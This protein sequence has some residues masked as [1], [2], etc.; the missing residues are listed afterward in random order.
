[1]LR[2]DFIGGM[3]LAASGVS[4]V[5]TRT[6]EGWAGVTVSAV[7]SVSADPPALLVCINQL[8]RLARAVVASGVFCVNL[9]SDEQ[10]ALSE[11]FAGRAPAPE[12]DR[13]GAA[14]WLRVRRACAQGRARRLRLHARA[15]GPVG[16]APRADRPCAHRRAWRRAAA[17]LL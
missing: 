6:P 15:R 4:I 1:M 13:F 8:S 2:D 12:G 5:T 17:R 3:R 16:L 14:S 7:C 9:L 10:Q 11:L